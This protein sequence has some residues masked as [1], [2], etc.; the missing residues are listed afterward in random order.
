MLVLCIDDVILVKV[1]WESCMIFMKIKKEKK[2]FLLKHF[3]VNDMDDEA[4]M[5]RI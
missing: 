4:V 3:E 5:I 1:T 2:N